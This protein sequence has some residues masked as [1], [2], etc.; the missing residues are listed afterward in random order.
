MIAYIQVQPTATPETYRVDLENHTDTLRVSELYTRNT[1]MDDDRY[2]DYKSEHEIISQILAGITSIKGIIT[3]AKVASR[4]YDEEQEDYVDSAGWVA[5]FKL[6]NQTFNYIGIEHQETP[7]EDQELP[8]P[9]AEI[10]VET[11][12]D[13]DPIGDTGPEPGEL[14]IIPPDIGAD[15]MPWGLWVRATGAGS[16]EPALH[17]NKPVY[18]CGDD[19]SMGPIC[20]LDLAYKFKNLGDN[21]NLLNSHPE[22]VQELRAELGVSY[23]FENKTETS[24]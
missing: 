24:E 7:E 12:E 10:T 18:F 9:P 5:S 17:F 4:K 16:F 14:L 15:A 8:E 19:G 13:S 1:G 6:Y 3:Q 23:Y 11:G 2:P 20:N 22:A 21:P